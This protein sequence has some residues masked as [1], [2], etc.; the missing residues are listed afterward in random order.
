MSSDLIIDPKDENT[1]FKCYAEI[2][3][4]DVRRVREQLLKLGRWP[5]DR[6]LLRVLDWEEAVTRL[7]GDADSMMAMTRMVVALEDPAGNL[8]LVRTPD[9]VSGIPDVHRHVREEQVKRARHTVG[10]KA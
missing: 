4:W 7:K 1:F 6:A 3:S 10:L 8:Y 5:K 2:M 9:L